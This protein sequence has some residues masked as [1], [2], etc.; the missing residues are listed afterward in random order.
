M[1]ALREIK[2]LKELH[3]P[4]IVQLVDVFI[5]GKQEKNLALVLEY[6]ESDLEAVIKDTSL[7]LSP[8]DIK[9]YMQM[10]LRA[11]S[12]CHSHNV[13]HR[14]IKPN[15]L[16]TAP[17]GA[18][19]LRSPC[20]VAAVIFLRRACMRRSFRALCSTH[21]GI[22]CRSSQACRFRAV[23]DLWKS[24]RLP[25]CAGLCALVPRPRASIRVDQLR[26]CC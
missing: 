25:Y 7:V 23:Q 3:S 26:P 22:W 13:I 11:L 1:T 15:N 4:D 2:I 20:A 10:A 9:A 8:S 14:D 6:M 12:T 17:T 24:G 16:L 18:T 19:P 21:Q 5:S